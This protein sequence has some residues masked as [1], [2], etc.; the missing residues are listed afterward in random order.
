[1]CTFPFYAYIS[2]YYYA[3]CFSYGYCI[4]IKVHVHF[5]N[6]LIHF[7]FSFSP[8][9][10]DFYVELLYLCLCLVHFLR[11]APVSGAFFIY[12]CLCLV[13]LCLCLVHFVHLLD[14]LFCVLFSFSPMFGDDF[15]F[16]SYR[17]KQFLSICAYIWYIFYA[18]LLCSGHFIYIYIYIFVPQFRTLLCTF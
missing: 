3:I 12:L 14:M 15:M 17:I 1:M 8:T 6:M 10:G 9:F 13:H 7:L 5:L 4:F 11:Y 16:D 18:M 2:F